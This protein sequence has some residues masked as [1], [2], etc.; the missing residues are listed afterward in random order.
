MSKK[1][2][3]KIKEILTEADLKT[4]ETALDEM[5]A[6]KVKVKSEL[7]FEEYRTKTDAL[8]ETY[9]A[10]RI[11]AET[12]KKTVELVESYDAKLENLEKKVVSKLDSFLDHVITE[13]ISDATI[14]KIAIN[15]TMQPVVEGI[16]KVLKEHFIEVDA[17]GTEVIKEAQNK[18]TEMEKK[19]SELIEKNMELEGKMEKTA[20]YLLIS[21]NTEGMLPSQKNRVVK[22]FKDK[23]FDE[24]QEKIGSFVELIKESDEKKVVASKPAVKREAKVIDSVISENDHTPETKKV[25]KEEA[26]PT[27]ASFA[28]R[29]M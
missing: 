14:E 4:F 9:C 15:E 29:F 8:A 24:V 26:E 25:I 21:E 18:A 20:T 16:K 23:H 12:E 5:V 2:T 1:I 28:E 27:F 17:E 19:V 10:E 3:D 7:M 11:K 13:Q 6:E 22:M